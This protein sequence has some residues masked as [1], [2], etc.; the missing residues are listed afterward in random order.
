ML[1]VRLVDVVVSAESVDNVEINVFGS[2]VS[3]NVGS[4]EA[5]CVVMVSVLFCING[6]VE[7][8]VDVVVVVETILLGRVVS[9]I[10]IE[11][12]DVG[13]GSISSPGVPN[14]SCVVPGFGSGATVTIP[15]SLVD[16]KPSVTAIVVAVPVKQG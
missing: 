4:W 12:E 3:N 13:S 9:I 1:G 8:D 11:V 14:G 16:D 15:L 10:L 5:V 7:V 2:V 6:V